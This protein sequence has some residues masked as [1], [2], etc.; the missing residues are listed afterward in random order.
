MVWNAAKGVGRDTDLWFTSIFDLFFFFH[1]A[2]SLS[3]TF[4]PRACYCLETEGKKNHTS[5]KRARQISVK[6]NA[7]LVAV[8]INREVFMKS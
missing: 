1:R 2:H 3:L 8:L 7:H 4:L 6:C 5:E